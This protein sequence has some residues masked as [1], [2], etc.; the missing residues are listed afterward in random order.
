MEFPEQWYEDELGFLFTLTDNKRKFWQSWVNGF[1]VLYTGHENTLIGWSGGLGMYQLDALSNEQIIEETIED[2]RTK[3]LVNSNFTVPYPSRYYISRWLSN[4]LTRGSYS[5]P[6]ADCDASGLS[7]NDLFQP[8][9]LTSYQHDGRS[10]D[11][12]DTPV[13]FFAGEGASEQYFS[14]VHGA[15]FT[16]ADQANRIIQ[17]A[18]SANTVFN[19]NTSKFL[20][21]LSV[22]LF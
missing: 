2:F 6:S 16:G 14:C 11:A 5:Y 4:P 20:L 15:Y 22:L 7:P 9:G 1:D 12:R 3:Y 10:V 21:F 8:I 17:Y 18:S 19:M 13:I